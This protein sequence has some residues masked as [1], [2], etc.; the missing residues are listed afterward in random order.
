M[1]SLER[2]PKLNYS[3]FKENA[4]RKKLNELGIRASGPKAVLER[5]HTEWVNLWNANCDSS[6]PRSKKELLQDLDVWERTQGTLAPASAGSGG[7]LM[8]KDFDGAAWAASH[9]SDF[10]TLIADARR[11]QPGPAST[12]AQTEKDVPSPEKVDLRS[13]TKEATHGKLAANH[14]NNPVISPYFPGTAM[15]SP[16]TGNSIPTQQSLINGNSAEDRFKDDKA[17]EFGSM[18]DTPSAPVVDSTPH[19]NHPQN[20]TSLSSASSSK[21]SQPSSPTPMTLPSSSKKARMFQEAEDPIVDAGSAVS[22]E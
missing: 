21:T 11:K 7:S 13:P 19:S 15:P 5:R 14:D 8:R 18:V 10:Q 1:K 20:R 17:D 9:H 6:R 22:V 12:S 3:L 4:L 16:G 2:L